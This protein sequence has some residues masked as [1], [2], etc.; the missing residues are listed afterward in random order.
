MCLRTTDISNDLGVRMSE[1]LNQINGI[2]LVDTPELFRLTT[3]VPNKVIPVHNWYPYLQGFSSEIVKRF[4]REEKLNSDST[5]LDPFNGVGTTTLTS[6]D[7]GIKS[8]GFDI[9][10]LAILVGRGKM[11]KSVDSKIVRSELQR[12]LDL[13]SAK[14]KLPDH[15]IIG[16]GL[17]E[18][19]ANRI[20]QFRNNIE[21]IS[22]LATKN[23]LQSSLISTIGEVSYIKK[24]GSHYRFVENPKSLQFDSTFERNT[25]RFL[26]DICSP[27]L[28]S[29]NSAEW[30][31]EL[32]DARKLPL[33]SDCIDAVITSPPY[34]NRHNYIA[35]NKLELFMMGC[36]KEMADYR[37]LTHS[38]LR[39][40]VEA[41]FNSENRFKHPVVENKIKTISKRLK[42][43]PN[44]NPKI[45]EMIQGYFDDMHMVI[46]ELYRVLKK[47][48]VCYFVVGNS[49]W[50]GVYIETD[51][52]LSD[53]FIQCGFMVEEIRV[54]RLKNNSAQQI[55]KF[56]KIKVRESV[57]VARK[58]AGS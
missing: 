58:V 32:S 49:A 14:Q 29:R 18:T 7:L 39:S 36:V 12:I 20:V 54:T 8:I 10:P 19:T 21:K 2:P 57:I 33:E 11:I 51:K 16:K 23:L 52:I 25:L 27:R 24:D 3:F 13:R 38:T 50:E 17:E 44:N 22:D 42:D 34:L 46:N 47:N 43:N 53:I 1:Y 37:E 6:R 48:G 26:S 5:I 41:K 15:G 30:K 35:Q 56:G 31:I 4:I 45:G 55:K 28:E 40:H 9:S